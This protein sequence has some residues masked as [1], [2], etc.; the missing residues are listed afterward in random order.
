MPP[1]TAASAPKQKPTLVP[2]PQAPATGEQ[3]DDKAAAI[4]AILDQ[5]HNWG[6]I[7][8]RVRKPESLVISKITSSRKAVQ[9]AAFSIF[10][11]DGREQ[12]VFIL[13]ILLILW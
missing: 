3:S 11:Q 12:S 5:L 1:A 2:T 7:G 13:L 10:R 9:M 6:V 8:G 4:D